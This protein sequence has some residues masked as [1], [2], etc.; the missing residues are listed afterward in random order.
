MAQGSLTE[1]LSRQQFQEQA[2]AEILHGQRLLHDSISFQAMDA[3]AGYTST[4]FTTSFSHTVRKRKR[5]IA[6]NPPISRAHGRSFG[7]EDLKRDCE[8]D[9]IFTEDEFKCQSACSCVCHR[10]SK[11]GTPALLES[12]FG[13]FHIGLTGALTSRTPCTERLCRRQHHRTA[14][15]VYRFPSWMLARAISFSYS[16]R[17]TMQIVLRAPR[18]I[19]DD[20]PILRFA[21]SRNL[22]S[23]RKLMSSGLASPADVGA[24][25]GLTALHIAFVNKDV[26]MCGF[27]VQHG[28]DPYYETNLRRAVIDI[29]RDE[30]INGKITDDQKEEFDCVFDELD[31][32]ESFNLSPL[33]KT[34]V[35]LSRVSLEMQ[36]STSTKHIDVTDSLGRTVLSAAAWRGDA[37][38]V[39]TLLRFGASANICTPTELSPLHRAIEGRSYEC[40]ELLIQ[41]GANVNHRNKRGRLPLHFACRID[42]DAKICELLLRSGAIVDGEDHGK[43]RPL[44]EAVVHGKIP[45]LKALLKYG[46]D[47][48]CQTVD[49]EFPLN[50]AI[51]KNN[52]EAI[53]LLLNAGATQSL[54]TMAGR[55]IVH[56]AAECANSETLLVLAGSLLKGLNGD[57]KD[58]EDCTPS[59]L[60]DARCEVEDVDLRAA[61]V[62]LLESVRCA[63]AA[64]SY[65]E[66][67]DVEEFHDALT[68]V[69]A[70]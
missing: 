47:V 36:L 5:S 70:V 35:G 23:I 57:E 44:H 48:N 51:A 9:D 28:A 16:T 26:E 11:L 20:A 66:K 30:L 60:F 17:S 42:D 15:F 61:F 52:V 21:A 46:A 13:T 59:Q 14:R 4:P 69:M 49:C 62:R 32:Y 31:D 7:L 53:H 43:G 34:V 64:E 41:Y 37:K 63:E 10:P 1:L 67:D 33:H 40:V 27:L 8:N 65:F 22:E 54:A 12:I 39:C 24:S 68:E 6:A 38:S 58:N 19:S 45:Q 50:I 2:L 25:Y 56:T 3:D 18:I 55:T 29:I